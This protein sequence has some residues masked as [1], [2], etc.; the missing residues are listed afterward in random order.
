[1][2][3]LQTAFIASKRLKAVFGLLNLA[4]SHPPMSTSTDNPGQGSQAAPQPGSP[5]PQNLPPRIPKPKTSKHNLTNKILQEAFEVDYYLLKTDDWQHIKMAVV[6]KLFKSC[7][8]GPLSKY[9]AELEP[10]IRGF[11][12]QSERL[13]NKV[14]DEFLQNLKVIALG[15]EYRGVLFDVLESTSEDKW[16]FV[17]I[18]SQ[19]MRA[20]EK[21]DVSSS[22]TDPESPTQ[23][24]GAT[25]RERRDPLSIDE[26]SN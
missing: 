10:A 9:R 1:M 5:N 20:W 23:G 16:F 12:H 19:I 21:K 26:P 6:V 17:W 24:P 18:A 15:E 8:N 25:G 4:V 3:E 11:N 2:R 22:S 13:K 7:C 14:Y